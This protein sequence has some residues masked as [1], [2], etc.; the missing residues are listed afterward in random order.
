MYCKYLTLS[1]LALTANTLL[2]CEKDTTS[3]PISCF[4][5]TCYSGRVLGYDCW[6]GTLIQVDS[7]FPIGKPLHSQLGID[8]LGDDNVIAAVNRLGSVAV[9]G[10][11]L[12]FTVENAFARQSPDEPCQHMNAA[13]TL[14]IPHLLLSNVGTTACAAAS[15]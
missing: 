11:R 1:L 14:P 8:S 9:R 12:Y 2:S 10:Q 7:P 5:G 4:S 15:F 13:I 6:N 3:G